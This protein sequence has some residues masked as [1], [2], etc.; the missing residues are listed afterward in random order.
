MASGTVMDAWSTATR[1]FAVG[2]E[3]LLDEADED[4]A[5][6]HASFQLPDGNGDDADML[7]VGMEKF[8]EWL[9]IWPEDSSFCAQDLTLRTHVNSQTGDTL[10]YWNYGL[11]DNDYGTFHFLLAGQPRSSAVHVMTNMDGDLSFLGPTFDK[12]ADLETWPKPESDGAREAWARQVVGLIKFYQ[13]VEKKLDCD[14]GSGTFGKRS[15]PIDVDRFPE[16]GED[17]EGDEG[18]E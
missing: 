18:D 16:D 6:L 12:Y 10:F 13:R 5:E 9:R 2:T 17:E 1:A 3:L 15:T 8:V 11:G 14:E 4:L 7:G